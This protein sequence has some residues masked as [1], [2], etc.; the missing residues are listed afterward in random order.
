[1]WCNNKKVY[2]F[3]KHAKVIVSKQKNKVRHAISTIEFQQKV[4]YPLDFK[5]FFRHF[6]KEATKKAQ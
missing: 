6:G 3:G 4:R 2:L 5:F 1:M